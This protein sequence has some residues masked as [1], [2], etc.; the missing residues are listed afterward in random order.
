M[1]TLIIAPWPS[2][3][4]MGLPEG[5][6]FKALNNGVP[7]NGYIDMV[8][9]EALLLEAIMQAEKDGYD[10]AISLCFA[11]TGV[12][13]ARKLVNMPVLGCTRVGVHLAAILGRKACLLQPDYSVNARTTLHTIDGYG[14]EGKVVM[15][16]PKVD[17]MEILIASQACLQTGE[18]T[19]P[20]NKLVET[21]I[22]SFNEDNTDSVIFG[23]GAML[24]CEGI[25]TAEL[26]K[27]GYNV[28]VI[29]GMSAAIGVAQVLNSLG[30]TH[31]ELA[32]PKC[33][34]I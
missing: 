26:K 23:S 25:L 30:I 5:V 11:D 29:N 2:D 32:Y 7:L 8:R 13:H 3:P 16:D 18:V 6:D 17:S 33:R 20:I 15:C 4:I 9:N 24:G 28:P 34:W 21:A 27:R 22:R 1:K 31:S 12:E 14:M 10:A 19:E